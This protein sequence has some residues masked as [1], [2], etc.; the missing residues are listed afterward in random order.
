MKNYLDAE[1]IELVYSG[2]NYFKVLDR[3]IEESKH[4]VHFQ[5]YIFESDKTGRLVA[6]SL[7]KAA[8]RG[9]TVYLIADAYGSFPFSKDLSTNLKESGV[10]FRLFSPFF[11][12][13]S[14]FW[15]RR[16][17]HKI[18]VADKRIALIGGIN[19]ADKYNAVSDDAST[20]LDYGLI[21]RGNICEYL[22]LLC[23]QVY[24]KKRRSGISSWENDMQISHPKKN[25]NLLRFRR[26]DWI[27]RKN[28]IYQSYAESISR[29]ERTITLVAS[30]FLPDKRLR[31]L[32]KKTSARGV[33]IKIILAG[34]S[35]VGSAKMAQ[36]YLYHFYL[37]NNIKLFEW[38]KSILHGKAMVVDSNWATMGSYNLNFLSHYISI[39]LNADIIDPKFIGKFESHLNTIIIENC[40][41][42]DLKRDAKNK[43]VFNRLKRWLAF[44]FFRFLTSVLVIKK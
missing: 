7:I 19:I 44:N 20:W 40:S 17:H 43:S 12:T 9:V 16:L 23:E 35:D 14:V 25:T 28:E 22:D 32:L 4:V 3:I 41:I 21:I 18:V 8:K 33:D 26:N 5:T 27:K 30:Y 42:I 29:S 38:Q 31:N 2:S 11:S 15:G 24:F 6:A 10:R 37:A 39:E 1:D 34:K 13:E 36:D